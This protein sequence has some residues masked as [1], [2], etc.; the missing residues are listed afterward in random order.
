M[1][2]EIEEIHSC[3]K[4]HGTGAS[5]MVLTG[6]RNS[7]TLDTGRPARST[8]RANH[9]AGFLLGARYAANGYDMFGGGHDLLL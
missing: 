1:F 2:P 3:S 7:R 5:A 9:Q 6:S 4:Q 8:I